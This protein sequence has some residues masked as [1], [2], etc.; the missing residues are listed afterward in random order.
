MTSVVHFLIL[1][2]ILQQFFHQIHCHSSENDN[3]Y[4]WVVKPECQVPRATFDPKTLRSITPHHNQLTSPPIKYLQD[5]ASTASW[6]QA[7]E[8]HSIYHRFFSDK[9]LIENGFFVEIGGLDGATFS[10]VPSYSSKH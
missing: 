5:F 4:P 1:V 9:K 2:G 6:A 3:N 7:Q 8:D 10:N